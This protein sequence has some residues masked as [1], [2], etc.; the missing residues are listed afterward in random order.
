M[1]IIEKFNNP[2]FPNN[3]RKNIIIIDVIKY[4]FAKDILIL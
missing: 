4:D 2:N 3:I 1:V